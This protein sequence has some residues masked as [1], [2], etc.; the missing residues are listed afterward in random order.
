MLHRTP[1]ASRLVFIF[2]V[3]VLFILLFVSL[4]LLLNAG[5]KVCE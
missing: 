3:L 4:L 2:G 1:Q 5:Q